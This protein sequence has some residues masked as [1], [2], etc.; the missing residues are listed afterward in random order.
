VDHH[1]HLHSVIPSPHYDPPLD[2]NNGRVS[3][4]IGVHALYAVKWTMKLHYITSKEVITSNTK[5]KQSFPIAVYFERKNELSLSR[6]TLV[7]I[8]EE[9]Q[10]SLVWA[11]YK[12][13]FEIRRRPKIR[14]MGRKDAWMVEAL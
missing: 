9:Q 7:A 2:H 12:Q 13:P 8:A 6:G 11:W 3:A 14:D 1:N 4:F 5:N 10:L